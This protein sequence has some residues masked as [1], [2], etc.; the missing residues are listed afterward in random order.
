VG[1]EGQ[2]EEAGGLGGQGGAMAV[3]IKGS[4]VL[5]LCEPL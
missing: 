3:T 5:P 2:A 4:S 1:L